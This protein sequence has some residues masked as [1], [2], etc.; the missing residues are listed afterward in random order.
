MPS[1]APID[2]SRLSHIF[3]WWFANEIS[4]YSVLSKGANWFF[5]KRSFPILFS[6]AV[7][8]RGECFLPIA[9]GLIFAL[10][11]VRASYRPHW[12]I[13]NCCGGIFR[14]NRSG[15]RNGI[16]ECFSLW[17]SVSMTFFFFL[18]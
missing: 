5:P 15:L 13:E 6:A 12:V 7:I 9:T 10:F 4:W 14:T 18:D 8:K 1:D 11:I 3:E 17:K 16:L 2:S